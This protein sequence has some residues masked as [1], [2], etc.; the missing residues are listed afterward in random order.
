MKI[1]LHIRST[2]RLNILEDFE[3]YSAY[4]KTSIYF[5]NEQINREN[6]EPFDAVRHLKPTFIRQSTL[7]SLNLAIF[8]ILFL[9]FVNSK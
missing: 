5:L 1:L 2:P 7:H 4:K 8:F 6:T 9:L 3:I